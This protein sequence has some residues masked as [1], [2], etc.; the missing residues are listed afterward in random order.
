MR[1]LRG[2]GQGGESLRGS[3]RAEALEYADSA[4]CDFTSCFGRLHCLQRSIF[5]PENDI[6]ASSALTDC[7]VVHS[8]VSTHSSGRQSYCRI[9]RLNSPSAQTRPHGFCMLGRAIE[10]PSIDTLTHSCCDVPFQCFLPH[11]RK[12]SIP[13]HT[14]RMFARDVGSS[15]VLQLLIL[16]L[17]GRT[18]YTS[19][20]GTGTVISPDEF[21]AALV[22]DF[23]QLPA[24]VGVCLELSRLSQ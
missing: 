6:H 17:I 16:P 19:A 13:S 22:P 1:I 3:T 2:G 5:G 12:T 18:G 15:K 20:S 21:V 9:S 11:L 23:A 10:S 4:L 24:H 7:F 14:I 8:H